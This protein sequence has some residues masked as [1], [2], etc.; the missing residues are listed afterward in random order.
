MSSVLRQ[1]MVF[2][3]DLQRFVDN[4]KERLGPQICNIPLLFQAV[5]E[6]QDVLRQY[7]IDL[8]ALPQERLTTGELRTRFQFLVEH[9]FA[10]IAETRLFAL[11][12]DDL[13]DADESYAKF[14]Y[15]QTIH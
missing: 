3:I 13:H 2:H 10:V 12:L 1:L 4:L 5:P 6:L 11:F 8:N 15:C 7:N 14:P 9:V